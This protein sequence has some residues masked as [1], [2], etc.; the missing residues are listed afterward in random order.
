M[1]WLSVNALLVEK[2]WGGRVLADVKNFKGSALVGESWEISTLPEG[3]STV[4]GVKLSQL[5]PRPLPYLVKLLET[6]DHLSVQVHPPDGPKEKGK[7][8]CWLVLEA[9]P[10]AGIFLGFK[11]GVTAERL[12]SSLS[13]KENVSDLLNF[14]PVK[15]GDFFYTPASTV[16][17][18]GRDIVLVEVQQACG[19]TYRVWDWN[20]VGDDG[21]PRSL[22]VEQAFSCLNFSSQH[23]NAKTFRHQN[24]ASHMGELT[25]VEHADFRFKLIHLSANASHDL[26]FMGHRPASLVCLN[27]SMNVSGSNLILQK[28]Q[29][30]LCKGSAASFTLKSQAQGAVVAWIE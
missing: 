5:L 23:N 6:S 2:I 28:Y 10:G 3:E 1:E 19:I 29:S 9:K 8:E 18:I 25:L 27:G 26:S 20:R 30:A 4:A 21:K 11:P 16:H 17:A 22:H 12:R 7:T 15:P 14:F 24:V 13:S